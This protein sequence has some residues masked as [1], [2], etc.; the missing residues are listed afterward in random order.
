MKLKEILKKTMAFLF[1]SGVLVV[2]NI[3]MCSVNAESYN[4]TGKSN[5]SKVNNLV[6]PTVLKQGQSCS[7]SG[8]VTIKKGAPKGTYSA[9]VIADKGKSYYYDS[10]RT[11]IKIKVK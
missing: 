11:I 2:N 8:K 9:A 1:I 4:Y 10:T 6:V 5:P 3:S 7:I